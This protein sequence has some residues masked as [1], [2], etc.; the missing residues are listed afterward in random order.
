MSA[1][2]PSDAPVRAWALDQLAPRPLS[3]LWPLHLAEGKLTMLDGDPGLGKSLLTL[4]LCARLTTGRPFPDGSPGP[5][6]ANVLLLSGEDDA[7]DTL[8]PRLQALG[9]DLGRVFV[10]RRE[11]D[12]LAEPV[13]LPSQLAALDQALTQTRAKLAVIDPVM[14]FLDPSVCVNSDPGVRRL[15]FPLARLF[16]R[17]RST[18][19]LVRHLNKRGRGPALYRGGGS[20]GL[21]GACRTGWL[22]APDPDRPG[23]RVLAQVKNNYAP[24]QPS[25]A[26]EVL[27]ADNALPTLSWLGPCAW[28][29]DQLLARA[30]QAPPAPGPRERAADFLTLFLEDGPRTAREVWAAAQK[31]GLSERTLSRA[32]KSLAVRSACATVDGRPQ[33]YWLL[34]GQRLSDA[35]PADE[36]QR[37]LEDWLADMERRF[38][39]PTPL[40]DL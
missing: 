26:F 22:V 13:R 30:G 17:H 2:P 24:L 15:L 11:R 6:P 23:R 7:D 18:G 35:V 31:A 27:G 14:A 5:G 33:N 10:L 12:D 37:E 9:A 32:K 36:D 29:A 28:T 38:P 20:I 19:T 39:P 40:D 25:L 4:D 1:L 34:P 3:W 21:L 16:T 8:R